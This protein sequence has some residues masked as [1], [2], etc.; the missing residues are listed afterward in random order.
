MYQ[1]SGGASPPE[2]GETTELGAKWMLLNG[3]LAFRTALYSTAKEYERNCDLDS[4]AAILTKKSSTNG[5]EFELSGRIT[6]NWE[7]FSG[8]AFMDAKILETATNINATTG[9]V[10]VAYKRFEVERARNTPAMTFNAFS[11]YKVTDK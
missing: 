9:A 11:T 6:S 4:T 10:T 2:R 1:L 8:L 7:I 3:D 5:L